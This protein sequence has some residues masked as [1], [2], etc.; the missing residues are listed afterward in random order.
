[1]TTL[2]AQARHL[3]GAILLDRAPGP[4]RPPGNLRRRRGVVVLTLVLGALLL[5]A[6]LAL[7]PGDPWF[8][9][10][11]LAVAATWAGGG[12][13]SGPLHL[14]RIRFPHR[15]RR[16]LLAPLAIGLLLGAAF[17]TAALAV[18]QVPPVRDYVAGLLL[19]ARRGSPLLIALVTVANGAAE[20]VFFR[21]AVFAALG[22]WHPVAASTVVYALATV[23][24][25]NPVLVFAAAVVGA[26]LGLQRRATG[27]ILAPLLTHLTW[28]MIMLSALPPL[29]PG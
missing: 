14:G 16:P 1:V 21:G 3:L 23:A 2:R 24:T 7:R 13:L 15:P 19:H 4:D 8:Y 25:G 9:P 11:T 22:R 27:G 26:V 18:R 20:E 29:F 28:S 5:G 10:M 6:S 12:A 17:F